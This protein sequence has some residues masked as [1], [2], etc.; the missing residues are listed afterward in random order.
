MATDVRNPS[1][2]ASHAPAGTENS[3][4]PPAKAPKVPAGRSVPAT[5]TI[6]A[7]LAILAT[8]LAATVLG[9]HVPVV[10]APV[11]AL[12][13][14][15]LLAGTC[16]PV[17]RLRPRLAL[18]G[19]WCLQAAVVVLGTSLS[20]RQ[21]AD[22]GLASLPVLAGTLG[23]ALVATPLLGR[24]L[25]V[26]G[27]LR[28]LVGAGTA[29]CGASAIAATAGV[30]AVTEAEIA[31]AVATIFA[32]NI[33]AVVVFPLLGHLLDLSPAGFGL[34]A[35][36]AV[37]DTSSVVAVGYAFGAAAG[38]HAVVVK[39]TRT[40]AIVPLTLG[41]AFAQAR[42]SRAARFAA[43]GSPSED[44]TATPP[45]PRA[46]PR[47]RK[48]VPGFVVLFVVAALANSL[49]LV[50]AAVHRPLGQVAAFLVTAALAA[51]GLSTR[52]GELRTT[53]PRPLLLG[54]LLWVCVAGTGLVLQAATNQW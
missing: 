14:G 3:P 9:G 42:A 37:N 29:I 35:G 50:P 12:A 31:Y 45:G 19:R 15:V 24:A 5:P 51:V 46:V 26:N 2:P 54:A 44:G 27:G 33:A 43:G 8:A 40:L 22:T 47:L 4:A 41:L 1:A 23:V 7:I 18:P 17:A 10:G 25:G 32:F 39:L 13:L 20:L 34:W 21:I 52:L 48:V 6:L 38:T 30:V 36:S 53:G 16:P 11:V 49:G 28:T